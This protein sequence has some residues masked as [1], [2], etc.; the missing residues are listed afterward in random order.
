[1][2]A[3]FVASSFHVW[4]LYGNEYASYGKINP[5]IIPLFHHSLFDEGRMPGLLL[6]CIV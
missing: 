3:S 6:Q 2:E 4:K 1:M 5:L